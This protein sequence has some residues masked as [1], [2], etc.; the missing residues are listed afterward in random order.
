VSIVI[1]WA[2][3]LKKCDLDQKI[4]ERLTTGKRVV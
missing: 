1:K 2:L 4:T 3:Y